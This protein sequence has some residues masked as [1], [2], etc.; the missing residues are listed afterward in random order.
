MSRL[1]WIQTVW[2]SDGIPEILDFEKKSTDNNMY[3]KHEIKPK[4]KIMWGLVYLF[5]FAT[6]T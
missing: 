1:I 2:H 5:F 3:K 4:S 6:L